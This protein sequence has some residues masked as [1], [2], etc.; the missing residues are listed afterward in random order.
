MKSPMPLSARAQSLDPTTSPTAGAESQGGAASVAE[1]IRRERQ[2]DPQELA[3]ARME[4]AMEEGYRQFLA[5]HQ[6]QATIA[7]LRS[8]VNSLA[9]APGRKSVVY[10]SEGIQITDRTRPLF[11][12]LIQAANRGNVTIYAIDAAGLRVQSQEA[13]LGRQVAVAGAQGIG[14]VGRGGA[15]TRDLEKQSQYVSS[16]PAAAMS[17]LADETGGFLLQNTND[18]AAGVGRMQQERT[19]YYLLA[20][21]STNPALDG[22]FRKVTINVKRHGVRLHGRSGYVAT[23]LPVLP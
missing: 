9:T 2:M 21:Q 23:P 7:G 1:R 19:T 12:S 4:I 17:R 15:W 5:E 14:D 20:Y 8:V 18:L 6:G 3:L 13:E 16:R 10:F 11:E 22:S